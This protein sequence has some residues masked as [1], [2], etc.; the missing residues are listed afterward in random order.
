MPNS[1][2][3]LKMTTQSAVTSNQSGAV[4]ASARQA[5]VVFFH[6]SPVH[7]ETFNHLRDRLAPG[8]DIAH[9]V[10]EDL[11]VAAQKVGGINE[12]IEFRVTD[13]LLRLSR[14]GVRL[15]VCT[16]SSLGGVVEA[17]DAPG[18]K[19]MRIDRPMAD[20]AVATGGPVALVAAFKPSIAVTRDLILNS[21]EA[22]GAKIEVTS[23][24]VPDCWDAFLRGDD[25]AYY[26]QIG[27][28]LSALDASA[29]VIVL[30]QA[31]MVPAVDLAGVLSV[32]VLSSVETGFLATVDMLQQ[33][34]IPP[35]H[36]SCSS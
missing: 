34:D 5:A 33:L 24:L 15:V 23:Y 26:K 10:R 36:S 20:E 32:P 14:A 2:T 30:A 1:L 11:L 28:Y 6:T 13:E 7:I 29:G 3:E 17:F 27:A 25:E 21:A 18:M 9:M 31:S 16:C 22:V 35:G 12:A 4:E 19:T 8:L